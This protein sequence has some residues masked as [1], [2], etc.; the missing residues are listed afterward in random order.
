MHGVAPVTFVLADD[1]EG[2]DAARRRDDLT[3]QQRGQ[4]AEDQRRDVLDH[5][6]AGL[7]RRGE[8][9]V[10][11]RSFR[12]G[13]MDRAHQAVVVG[14]ARRQHRLDRVHRR[15][16]R[17]VEGGVDGRMVL[18]R[19]TAREVHQNVGAA[20]LQLQAQ[21][22]GF[23][24]AVCREFVFGDAV[25]QRA[26]GDAQGGFGAILDGGGKFGDVVHAVVVEKFMDA[27]HADAVRADNGVQVTQHHF[28]DTTVG[29]DKF[30]DD[31]HDFAISVEEIGHQPRALHEH[32]L[33][34]EVAQ[35]AAHVGDMRHGAQKGDELALVEDGRHQVVVGQVC[36]TDPGIVGGEDVPFA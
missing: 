29:G 16:V 25:G 23:Q 5:L 9:A 31:G 19:R 36:A 15:R 17:N 21:G 22:E 26:D 35:V 34:F 20:D 2:E 32:V 14:D 4:S 1:V 3:G 30:F 7:H 8:G 33:C 24:V 13:D 10:D 6:G 28:G 18:L 11:N 12:R 27:A